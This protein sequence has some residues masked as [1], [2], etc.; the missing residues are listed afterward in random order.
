[1]QQVQVD[2]P[3]RG[4]A[5]DKSWR[6]RQPKA[7]R[8]QEQQ[9]PMANRVRVIKRPF[10]LPES[11]MRTKSKAEEL[12]GRAA[13]SQR[14]S[15]VWCPRV[16]LHAHEEP[17]VTQ[18]QVSITTKLYERTVEDEDEEEEEN[19]F[20]SGP[21][22][23]ERL[24]DSSCSADSPVECQRAEEEEEEEEEEGK[25]STGPLAADWCICGMVSAASGNYQALSELQLHQRAT[26]S[27]MPAKLC[28]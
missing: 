18:A 28:Y 4:P 22:L 19:V 14:L 8:C 24:Y 13:W 20:S 1:M 25:C 16:A 5:E 6:E 2:A 17:G 11:C 15:S 9:L 7:G 23:R 26:G 10:H 12:E 27:G 21:L 3:A